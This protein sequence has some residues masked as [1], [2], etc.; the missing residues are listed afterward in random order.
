MKI[1]SVAKTF[2]TLIVALGVCLLAG[3]I[4]GYPALS[5][6]PFGV[7]IDLH[8]ES[9][10]GG[11]PGLLAEGTP[12]LP[13]WYAGLVKPVFSPPSWVFSPVWM[14]SFALMGLVLF[15]ILRSGINQYEV[16]FGL[17][18]FALQLLFMLIWAYAFFGIHVLFIAF[19]CMI[20]LWATLLCAVIQVIRL[21]QLRDH[22]PQ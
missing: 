3:Y 10:L 17:I 19:L 12:P 4:G 1:K 21:S 16:T 9:Y 7:I 11:Y 22:G 6:M 20:A 13:V 2:L 14:V 8:I 18:L 15:L 5:R